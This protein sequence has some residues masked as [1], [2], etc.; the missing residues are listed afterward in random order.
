MIT[1]N[2]AFG[3]NTVTVTA[4]GYRTNKQ[5]YNLQPRTSRM[6]FMEKDKNDG[7]PYISMVAD[8]KMYYD[9]RTQTRQFTEGDSTML[10]LKVEGVW[11]EHSPGRYIIYQD[12]IAGGA[13]GKSISSADGNFSFAPGKLLNPEVPV[14]LKMVSNNGI[15]SEPI[16]INLTISKKN[17]VSNQFKNAYNINNVSKIK[18]GGDINANVPNDDFKKLFPLD[19]SIEGA[20]VPVEISVSEDADGYTIKGVVG[21][22]SGEYTKGLLN[23]RSEDDKK[24]WSNL[25]KDIQ[26]A[27]ELLSDRTKLFNE[28]RDK[29]AKT[30][31]KSGVSFE[32]QVCGFIEVKLDKNGNIVSGS[33]GLV[34]DGG[35]EY[36]FGRTFAAGPVP[37]YFE[38]KVGVGAKFQGDFTFY[39]ADE[40]LGFK[41]G[42]SIK[43]TL[44]KLAVGGGVGVHG[45][46]TVG[47]EGGAELEMGIAPD[48]EGTIEAYGAVNIKI[49]F[50]VDFQWK[51]AKGTWQLWPTANK[52]KALSLFGDEYEYL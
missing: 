41:L 44:P 32:V 52:A 45:V 21:F 33:G 12:S 34:V 5:Y 25:K 13:A 51:F 27:K 30:P 26:N 28:R 14:K 15:E 50:V 1:Y 35:A 40:G 42:G 19:L 20:E 11:R 49:L 46:A 29:L 8:T 9:L 37:V 24:E 3:V 16:V 22:I 17:N 10:N 48:W 38:L 6:I 39:T 43:I 31:W 4:D 18:L 23:G 7:K 36:K 2:D 47:V